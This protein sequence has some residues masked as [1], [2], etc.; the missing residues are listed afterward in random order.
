MLPD[1]GIIMI[2]IFAK[3]GSTVH[4]TDWHIV[5]TGRSMTLALT[6][7]NRRWALSA[8]YGRYLWF[9]NGFGTDLRRLAPT[10]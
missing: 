4:G 6:L 3:H 1:K 5:A 8:S 2:R 9:D 10:I 7:L